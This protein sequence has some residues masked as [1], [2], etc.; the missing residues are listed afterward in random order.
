M[1]RAQAIGEAWARI[2][3][4][5][6][7]SFQT[8]T[9]LVF[10]YEMPGNYLRV[11][12]N[13]A[14]VN[15]SL[16]RTNYAKPVDLM[17]ADCPGVLKERQGSF[18]TWAILE[19]ASSRQKMAPGRAAPRSPHWRLV[20]LGV[21]VHVCGEC[22]A[23]G[24]AGAN[25]IAFGFELAVVVRDDRARDGESETAP[26]PIRRDSRGVDTMEALEDAGQLISWNALTGVRD[27]DLDVCAAGRH[28]HSYASVGRGVAK[29]VVQEVRH[30]LLQAD[31]IANDRARQG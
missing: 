2:E 8:K 17:P 23:H 19:S 21:C 25:A 15:R 10:S 6:G 26:A 27:G 16:S 31:G 22:D 12:S 14:R 24:G 3:R 30:H 5:A 1:R 28:V 18:Y 11:V 4:H 20:R 9:G 7:E 13:G 29:C